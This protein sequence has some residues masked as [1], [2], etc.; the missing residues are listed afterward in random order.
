MED[1]Q[2]NNDIHHSKVLELSLSYEAISHQELVCPTFV[3][4]M[5]K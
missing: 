2:I 3:Q 5:R 4:R 1:L